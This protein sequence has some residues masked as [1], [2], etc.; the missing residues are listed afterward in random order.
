MPQQQPNVANRNL[1]DG[2]DDLELYGRSEVN[3]CGRNVWRLQTQQMTSLGI[4]T[5]SW[6]LLRPNPFRH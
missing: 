4:V 1:L 5:E 3:A 2:D 6:S